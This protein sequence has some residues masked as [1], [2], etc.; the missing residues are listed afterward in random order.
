AHSKASWAA[1]LRTRFS[2]ATLRSRI[3]TSMERRGESARRSGCAAVCRKD[4]P[5]ET[6]VHGVI[7]RSLGLQCTATENRSSAALG[8]SPNRKKKQSEHISLRPL[9]VQDRQVLPGENRPTGSPLTM[10]RHNDADNYA[11]RL[12]QEAESIRR[13]PSCAGSRIIRRFQWTTVA[14][15]SRDWPV[16]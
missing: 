12:G 5:P 11:A 6:R 13:R 14:F 3:R 9:A 15:S 8:N 10:L 1:R 16:P 7:P 4:R 2:P